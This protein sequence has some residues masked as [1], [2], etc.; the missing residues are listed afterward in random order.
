LRLFYH[1]QILY[2][3]HKLS[4][5]Q[6]RTTVALVHVITKKSRQILF[7]DHVLAAKMNRLSK[8]KTGSRRQANKEFFLAEINEAHGQ[9]PE[10]NSWWVHDVII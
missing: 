4:Y 8:A 3:L 7:C 2:R 6:V 1:Y 5:N 10:G 9:Y